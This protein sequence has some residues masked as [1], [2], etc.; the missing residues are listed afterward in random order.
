VDMGYWD[1]FGSSPRGNFSIESGELCLSH[2]QNPTIEEV[3]VRLVQDLPLPTYPQTPPSAPPPLFS[4][5]D[6]LGRILSYHFTSLK[7]DST[8]GS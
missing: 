4:Y 5:P 1:R 7:T 6:A 2:P 8:P 3:I